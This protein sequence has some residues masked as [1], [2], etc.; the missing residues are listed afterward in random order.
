MGRQFHAFRT[1]IASVMHL[2]QHQMC[3]SKEFRFCQTHFWFKH[4]EGSER[5]GVLNDFME[6]KSLPQRALSVLQM[7]LINAC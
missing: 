6:V 3:L 7:V 4:F 5:K 2:L 1:C